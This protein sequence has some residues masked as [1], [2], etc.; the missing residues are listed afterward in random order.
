[1]RCAQDA[2]PG[3]APDGDSQVVSVASSA[4]P[5][6]VSWVVRLRE[7]G[8]FAGGGAAWGVACEQVLRYWQL[9]G[10]GRGGR[11]IRIIDSDDRGTH[12]LVTVAESSLEDLTRDWLQVSMVAEKGTGFLYTFP[13]R[14]RHPID[15]DDIESIRLGCA[16]VT[17]ADMEA[18]E[19]E[20]RR[21]AQR[22][23]CPGC[24]SLRVHCDGGRAYVVASLDDRLVRWVHT[25]QD[26]GRWVVRWVSELP[27]A[28]VWHCPH[29][30]CQS[31]RQADG[32]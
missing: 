28:A 21:R 2:E 12:W 16:R 5:P 8:E 4:T 9:A 1:V 6:P 30:D 20:Q 3:A 15:A 32:R 10:L 13:T 25:C 31:A 24:G 18:S 7:A 17:P 11:R 29:S 22:P 27:A 23:T 14:S 26:C 19:A